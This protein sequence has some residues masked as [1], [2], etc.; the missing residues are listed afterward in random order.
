[1]QNGVPNYIDISFAP[2]LKSLTDEHGFDYLQTVLCLLIDD[3]C[4]SFSFKEEKKMNESQTI[5]CASF[6]LEE[7][8][9]YRIEDYACMFTLAK[10]NKLVIGDTGKV[11][12]RIDIQL[13][14]QFKANYD[15]YRQQEI[16]RLRKIEEQRLSELDAER[17]KDLPNL[18]PDVLKRWKELT[19]EA[20][21]EREEK[22]RI[23][24]EEAE[25]RRKELFE[26]MHKDA[27]ANGYDINLFNPDIFGK[28]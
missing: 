1:M 21:K 14:S 25:Q 13:I 17:R 12:D 18:W 26:R 19:S 22:D 15:L 27:V 9:D 6:L 11:F 7:C 5:E 2:S 3:F 23:E 8:K 20:N 4:E 28:K 24:K 16:K 10:R